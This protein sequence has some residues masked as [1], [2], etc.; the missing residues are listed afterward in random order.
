MQ[1]DVVEQKGPDMAKHTRGA[2]YVGVRR[3][4]DS[5]EEQLD[6]IA[7]LDQGW[8]WCAMIAVM[9]LVVGV[10]GCLALLGPQGGML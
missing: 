2:R 7:L 3:R 8:F 9:V 4:A 10:F 1:V 6:H 5:R